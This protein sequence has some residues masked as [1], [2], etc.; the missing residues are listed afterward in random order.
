MTTHSSKTRI[1]SH[2]ET[3]DAN[4]DPISGAPGAHPVGT[5]VGTTGGAIGGAAVGGAVG[6]PVG[7][8]VGAVIGG[9][10]GGLVGKGVGEAVNPTAEDAYWREN[11]T[12]GD[13]YESGKPYEYYQP[14]YRSGYMGY[15]QYGAQGQSFEQAEPQ[16]R[17]SYERETGGS[18]LGWERARG[19]SRAAWNRVAGSSKQSDKPMEE[20]SEKSIAQLNSFLRG[21][22]SAIG[23]YRLAVTRLGDSVH[24][25]ALREA[26]SSHERRAEALKSHISSSGGTPSESAG[27]WG[28]VAKLYEGGMAMFGEKAAINALESGEDH[29]IE[30]F[31]RGLDDLDPVCL[32]FMRRDILPEQERTHRLISDLKHSL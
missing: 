31:K 11:Y 14:A 8:V 3:R 18:G 5:G 17:S 19:A 6:G 30:D 22:L 10:A 24:A 21:E 4:R 12:K 28:A 23:T 32:D 16:V 29:G 26:L 15:S 25:G 7:G 13:S 9:V 1:P 27:V 2:P 20:M